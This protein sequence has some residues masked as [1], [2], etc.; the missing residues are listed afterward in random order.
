MQNIGI[1]NF[2][3][4][5]WQCSL[6]KMP[7]EQIFQWKTIMQ[8][9]KCNSDNT[10]RL[11][12][13]FNHGTQHIRVS[14]SISGSGAGSSSGGAGG[15]ASL[16]GTAQTNMA[17]KVAPPDKKTHGNAAIVLVAGFFCVNLIN[18]ALGFVL[19]LLCACVSCFLV[20]KTKTYNKKVFPG[21]YQHWKDSWLCNKCGNIYHQP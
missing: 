18:S 10:Q 4:I 15:T 20:Y 11:E 12:V 2:L 1:G 21:L 5:D 9:L 14:G 3:L 13:V 16:Y 6:L 8:C 7:V 19:L 17:S